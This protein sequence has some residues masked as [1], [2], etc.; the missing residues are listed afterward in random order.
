MKQLFLALAL[1]MAGCATVGMPSKPTKP[2]A[3]HIDVELCHF[4]YKN[5]TPELRAEIDRRLGFGKDEWRL[6]DENK[7]RNGISANALVCSWG[8]PVP[9][10]DIHQSVGQWGVHSQ[11][12]YRK[13]TSCDATYVY[14]QNG[15]VTSWSD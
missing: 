5:P 15:V 6:I 1:L 11:W 12:V 14:T 9:F 3:Q 7:I 13:C 4:Y 8:L 2:L 10:G